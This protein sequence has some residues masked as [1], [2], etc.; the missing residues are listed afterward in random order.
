[1]GS[2]GGGFGG[3]A[4]DY[5]RRQAVTKHCTLLRTQ[6]CLIEARFVSALLADSDSRK[7]DVPYTG[8]K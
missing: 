2:A 5:C 1:M 8:R 4:A 7:Y 6:F 3:T